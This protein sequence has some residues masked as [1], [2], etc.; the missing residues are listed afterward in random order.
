MHRGHG[1][2]DDRQTQRKNFP[3]SE[4]AAGD[5]EPFFAQNVARVCL[6]IDNALNCGPADLTQISLFAPSHEGLNLS[7]GAADFVAVPRPSSGKFLLLR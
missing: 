2:K 1:I 4:I 3:Q 5:S 6:G 7:P